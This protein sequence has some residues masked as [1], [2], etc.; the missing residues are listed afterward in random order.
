MRVV[1]GVE[2][3][4]RALLPIIDELDADPQVEVAL[5]LLP[6][7]DLGARAFDSFVGRLREEDATRRPLGTIPFMFAAF[8]P[9][10]AV[11]VTDAERLIPYLRR[12]PDPTIQLVRSSSI[13]AVR[14]G[15]PQGTQLVDIAL[16]ERPFERAPM[17]LRERIARA[18]LATV[19]RMGVD[20]LTRKLDDIHRDREV[21]YRRLSVGGSAPRRYP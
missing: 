15:T 9:E 4:H 19:Q 8:H 17:D 2:P 21:T 16:M 3:N 20:E 5:L 6:R 13:D 7:L 11:D 18:N 1:L 14:R 10:A 12:T